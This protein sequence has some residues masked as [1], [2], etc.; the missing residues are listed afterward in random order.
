MKDF[1]KT[2]LQDTSITMHASGD[3]D[4][5]C[6]GEWGYHSATVVH[7]PTGI[8]ADVTRIIREKRFHIQDPVDVAM[9]AL[10]EKLRAYYER[11]ELKCAKEEKPHSL[12]YG[13]Y[14]C[15]LKLANEMEG[16]RMALKIGA[17]IGEMNKK[18]TK[19]PLHPGEVAKQLLL[20]SRGYPQFCSGEMVFNMDHFCEESNIDLFFAT[21]FFEEKESVDYAL[22]YKIAKVIEGTDIRFWM[23]L[24]EK[25]DSK[26]IINFLVPGQK[27]D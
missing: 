3:C 20:I 10:K 26:P 24:Q 25:Y 11:E 21:R 19:K 16:P 14:F 12:G 9:D 15:T 23:D 1:L 27:N 18:E 5:Y 2:F 8:S 6:C 17:G 4:C 7:K 22:A 13:C